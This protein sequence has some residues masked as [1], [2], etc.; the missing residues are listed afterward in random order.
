M[1]F[2]ASQDKCVET[3]SDCMDYTYGILASSPG[4]DNFCMVPAAAC[5]A[6]GKVY[7][8][9]ANKCSNDECSDCRDESHTASYDATMYNIS[10][11]N[12]NPLPKLSAVDTS[13]NT[14][15]HASPSSCQSWGPDSRIYCPA[16]ESCLLLAP[17]TA[18]GV[19][20]NT[21]AMYCHRID[22]Q[23]HHQ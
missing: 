18:T 4:P 8:E 22:F 11:H 9:Q 7:C 20:M 3:C 10:Y 15:V 13:S 16:S 14:C 1:V 17:S 21:C 19:S 5:E 12:A 23:G 2:C 6:H